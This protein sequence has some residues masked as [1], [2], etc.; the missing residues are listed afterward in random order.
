MRLKV[1]TFLEQEKE[2]GTFVPRVDGW[3]GGFN[4]DFSRSLGEGGWL[5]MTYPSRYG[6]RDASPLDRFVVTEELLAAGAPVAAHW[7]GERQMG[8]SILQ[9]GTEEQKQRYV[10]GIA[11]GEIYFSIGMSEPN[12][13]SDLASVRTRGDKVDGGW[14]VNGSK[15][16]TGGAHIAHAMIALLRTSPQQPDNRHAG[17]SQFIIDLP[18]VGVQVRPITSLDGHHHFN[19]VFFTDVFVPDV[20]V[21]G[22]VGDGWKQVTAELAIERSGPERVLSSLPL[23]LLWVETCRRGAIEAD[24]G[25]GIVGSL[26]ARLWVL[27]QMSLAVAGA[28][29]AGETVEVEAALAKELG[30]RFEGQLVDAI[31]RLTPYQPDLA[32][33]IPLSSMCAQA[34]LH[35]PGF[36][37][38]G[39]TNE[40]LRGVVARGLGVR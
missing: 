24:R 39:G 23:L 9:W 16:W 12:T 7:I 17:L 11:R 20:N 6:G 37:L 14:L 35:T 8:P 27:R 5:G 10:P 40:I 30:T 19:E 32:S 15:I 36:T 1:R 21:L 33:P 29:A 38:R 18:S 28:L 22:Q 3:L 2:R 25:H 31:R 34:I 26:I 4:T 13:G